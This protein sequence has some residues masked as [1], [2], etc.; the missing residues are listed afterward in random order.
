M[1]RPALAQVD[2]DGVGFH[3]PLR[4]ARRR[5]RARTGRA[6]PCGQHAADLHGLAGDRRGV[7]RGRPGSGSRGRSGRS[8][9]RASGRGSRASRPRRSGVT[10]ICTLGLRTSSPTMRSSTMPPPSRRASP[11]RRRRRSR[12]LELHRLAPPARARALV[13]AP[14]RRQL[15]Q[16]DDRVARARTTPSLSLTMAPATA[17]R[18]ARRRS[19]A[20][21]DVVDGVQVL[22]PNGCGPRPR[23]R[24]AGNPSW[25]PRGKSRGSAAYIG[26][27]SSEREVTLARRRV[28]GDEVRARRGRE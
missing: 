8:A 20:V 5:S 24:A 22:A 4:R 14:G 10:R 1:R 18:A 12:V 6:R 3:A 21:D 19:S 17:G 15:A 23:R 28:V 16:V 13:A 11:G 26:M 25:C 2:L 9:R 7:A 27:P